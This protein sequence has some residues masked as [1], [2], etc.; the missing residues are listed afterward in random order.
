ME[1]LNRINQQIKPKVI[2]S[3]IFANNTLAPNATSYAPLYTE[4]RDTLRTPDK[5]IID[6]S[7]DTAV[8]LGKGV[9]GVP[10]A[11]AG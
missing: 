4:H 7:Q 5:D 6:Y 1:A 2:D 11:L 3:T 8:A 9:V 10:Q